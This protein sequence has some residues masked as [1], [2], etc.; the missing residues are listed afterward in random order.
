MNEIKDIINLSKYFVKKEFFLCVITIVLIS[1]FDLFTISL[2]LPL[3]DQLVNENSNKLFFGIT[4]LEKIF[5]FQFIQENLIQITFILFI[6]SFFLQY[7]FKV[8][9]VYLMN[10]F[11][12][13]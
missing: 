8:F 6:L 7:F 11:A 4:F 13:L 2:L 1:I 3:M 9:K 12:E 5:N 10:K